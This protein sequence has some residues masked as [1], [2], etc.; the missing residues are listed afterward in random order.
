MNSTTRKRIWQVA[1][2]PLLA[3]GVLCVLLAT[4]VAI[5][6]VPLGSMNLVFGLAIAT[7]KTLVIVTVFMELVSAPGLIKLAAATGCVWLFFLLFLMS[8]DY[9][10]R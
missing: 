5:A 1:R 2:G 3:W 10:A 6:Y 9:L 4:T 8:T 7:A